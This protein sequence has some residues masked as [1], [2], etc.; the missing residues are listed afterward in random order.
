LDIVTAVAA[1]SALA[2][3]TALAACGSPTRPPSLGDADGASPVVVPHEAC[4]PQSTVAPRALGLCGDL[5]LDAAGAPPNLYFIIDRSGSMSEVVDG[6]QKYAAVADAAVKL[7]R[8][9]GARAKIGAAVF[10][11]AL[12]AEPCA[13][14]EEVFPTTLGDIGPRNACEGDGPATRAFSRSISLPSRVDPRGSTPTAATL[15]AL[16]PGLS[17]LGGKT[18]VILATDGGPNCNAAA[19]C[20]AVSCIPNIE[21]ACPAT[22]NCCDAETYGPQACLD[23]EPTRAAVAEL[24]RRGVLTYVVG[25]PGSAPYRTLLGDLAEAGGTARAGGS[26]YYEVERVSELDAVLGAIGDS[27]TVACDLLL[28]E[29]PPARGRVNVYLDQRLVPYGTADGWQW[30]QGHADAGAG[31]ADSSDANEADVIATTVGDAD[32]TAGPGERRF[33]LSGSAC[34]DLESGRVRQ[35]RVTF[36]CATGEVN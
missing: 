30:A 29:T 7:V 17:A 22:R 20:T 28:S 3:A 1:A 2:W 18:A 23:A 32:A 31:E 34:A 6:Q 15:T 25:V 24:R 33:R 11:A 21:G 16:T 5:L 9:L 14:G 35:L 26:A 13:P 8:S 27:V 12:G 19:R 10:P 4:V 36:G